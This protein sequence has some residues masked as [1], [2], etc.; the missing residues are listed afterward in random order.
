MQ[1]PF[2]PNTFLSAI[3]IA[4][5]NTD[6][7]ADEVMPRSPVEKYDFA[8]T[9]YDI[10]ERFTIQTTLVGRKTRPNQIDYKTTE[11]KS[12]VEDYGLDSP[13]PQT[14]I[15]N[16]KHNYNPLAHAAEATTDL[17]LLD[18]EVRVVNTVF[19]TKNYSVNK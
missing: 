19:N 11:E 1:H 3:A 9:K 13:V 18:R 6:L 2:T 7:I 16:A 8:W 5:R 15:D 4:Y 10:A 17:I 12:S 14:D